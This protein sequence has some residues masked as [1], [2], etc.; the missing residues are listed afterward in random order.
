MERRIAGWWR[1][2]PLPSIH[3]FHDNVV[4]ID[5]C[6][7]DFIH[8]FIHPSIH[9]SIHSSIHPCG[10]VS[11]WMNGWMNRFLWRSC[12][13]RIVSR[14]G[15]WLLTSSL[16]RMWKGLPSLSVWRCAITYA[17]METDGWMDGRMDGWVD[18]WVGEWM[19]G[20][21]D[22]WRDGWIRRDAS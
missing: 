18:G 1:H 21:R 6:A 19:D 20:W 5:I 3:R 7:G 17:S 2:F 15:F 22:R 13:P 16:D 11:E 14:M 4:E 9:L 12:L 10:D 8:P